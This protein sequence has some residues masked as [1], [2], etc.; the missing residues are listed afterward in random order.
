VPLSLEI[1]WPFR[2]VQASDD[3]FVHVLGRARIPWSWEAN[4]AVVFSGIDQQEMMVYSRSP[5][6]MELLVINAVRTALDRGQTRFYPVGQH[7]SNLQR[8]RISASF[9]EKALPMDG[10]VRE[11]LLRKVHW[12]G[13][14]DGDDGSRVPIADPYDAIYLGR[15]EA[16]LR[17]LARAECEWND[18]PRFDSG[19]RLAHGSIVA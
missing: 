9:L 18:R 7:P 5:P 1:H 4:F 13:F 17:Q 14:R 15:T 8:V 10:E 2:A 19:T 11:F 6:A 12:L 3:V 16:R